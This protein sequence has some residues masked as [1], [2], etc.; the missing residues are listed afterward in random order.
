MSEVTIQNLSDLIEVHG[1]EKIQQL[2]STFVSRNEDVGSFLTNKRKAIN[3]DKENIARTYLLLETDEVIT[4]IRGYISISFKSIY[5]DE[6]TEVSNRK[7]GRLGVSP[8]E[9]SFIA[10]LIAQYGKNEDEQHECD[11]KQLLG[12]AIDL[13][14][15][16]QKKIGGLTTVLLECD[17]DND[18]LN[19]YY[20]NIGFQQLQIS[21][22]LSQ[23]Y[24]FINK[25]NE[26]IRAYSQLN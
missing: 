13:S 4:K 1:K 12:Y 6:S 19:T 17:K 14:I 21:E 9:N 11:P 18:K 26:P 10:L 25:G 16:I 23:Y 15:E 2:L 24:I 8:D 5:I 22:D 7:K 3:F 20:E